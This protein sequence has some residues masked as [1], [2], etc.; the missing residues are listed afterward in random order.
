MVA[1]SLLLAAAAAVTSFAS[2]A[3]ARLADPSH[4]IVG[5]AEV[6]AP[7]PWAAAVG[8]SRP[9]MCSGSVV[10]RQWVLTA[11]HCLL[12]GDHTM[13]VAVGSADMAQGEVITVAEKH[14]RHDLL[15]LK[16]VSPATQAVP[17]KLA[18]A[19]PPVGAENEI[20][21]WGR[22]SARAPAAGR[23]KVATVK[24][25]RLDARD[26]KGGPAIES[27]KGSGHAHKGDSGGPQFY[28]GAQVGVC[29]QGY[30]ERGIQMY[31]SVARSREWIRATAGV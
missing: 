8:W 4:G 3:H 12:P 9:G 15:L 13:T 21:G 5:G 10:A 1:L 18:D 27:V 19:D 23:L 30:V 17:V 22:T 6:S 16:L 11:A 31:A 25:T 26:N 14:T 24:V 29:S 2:A 7:T 28:Q 20:F